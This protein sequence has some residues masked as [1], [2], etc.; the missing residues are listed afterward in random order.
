MQSLWTGLSAL[1]AA[2]S[3]L[4]Q[5]SGNIANINTVGYGTADSTFEDLLTTHLGG[6]A[7]APTVAGRYTQPGLWEGT[8]VMNTQLMTHFGGMGLEKTGNSLD[9]A[10]SAENEFF[11]L[12]DSNGQTLYTKAGN[13]QLKENSN[14]TANLV[15]TGGQQVESTNGQ[16]ITIPKGVKSIEVSSNGQIS[17]GG[18]TGQ[19]IAVAIVNTPSQF[20]RSV[21]NN[22]FASVQG[23]PSQT[24][25][26]SAAGSSSGIHVLQ[27][28]LTTNNVDLTNE[29]TDLVKA[30]DYYE[31]NAK[32][33]NIANKL[34]QI[35]NQIR[36]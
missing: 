15:T 17:Y 19:R 26:N 29:M 14:G 4:S 10:L 3:Q 32:A 18:Q 13:F 16:P 1:N 11:V 27:G 33:I 23:L 8:G 7:T 36:P 9:F 5:V 22:N 35:D 34:M 6:E 20:L 28:Y 25:A 12:K 31:S 2:S 24:I 30:Q 21:G